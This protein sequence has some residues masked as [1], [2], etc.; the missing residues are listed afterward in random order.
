MKTTLQSVFTI[1]LLSL[2]LSVSAQ[3]RYLDDVFSAVTVTSD[4]TYATNISILPMLQGLPPGPANLKCDIYEPTG[5]VLTDRPVIILVHTGSFLPP[6]LNGQPTGS[7]SDLSIVEQCTRWAKKGYVAVAM[8]NRLGWNPTSTDQN[9][10][11]S[12]LIQAAYRGIQDAR[13]MVRYMRMTE[14]TGNS[15]GIDESKIVIGGQ[16]TGAYIS[17]GVATLDTASEMYL[18]KFMN[19]STTPPSP[20]V[21]A[22][23]FGNVYGTDSTYL[24][25]FASPTGQTELWNIPNNPTYSSDVNMA[26]NLGGALADISWLDAGEIPIVSFHCEKDPYGP[27]DTGDVIVPT[28]GNIVVEVMG[29][30]VVQH[31]ANQYLNNDPFALAGISDVYT[32]A[33]NVNN[34]GLE[35]LNVFITPP[36]SATSNAFGE[37]WEEEGA[38]W[39]WWDNVTYGIQ[40]EAVNGIPGQTSAAFFEAN[41]ILGSPNMS[42]ANGNLYIDTIQGY[43]NPRLFAVLGFISGCTDATSCNYNASA[44]IDD[45]TCILPDGCTDPLAC[46]YDNLATCDDGSCLTDYGCMN[47]AATNYDPLATCPDSCIFP[48]VTYGCTDST[49][50][51]YNPTASIDDTSCCFIAGCTDALAFNYDITACYDD[52]SCIPVALGCTYSV[53]CNYDASANSDDGSC[54]FPDGCTD[55]EAD[56]YDPTA[57]CDDGSCLYPTAINEEISGLLM[58]PNPANN[59][60]TIISHSVEIENINIYNLNGQL[61]LN[62]VLNNHNTVNVSSLESGIYI[63]DILSENTSVKRKLIIE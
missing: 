23:F 21:Y 31:Y 50:Y 44:N 49:A 28:T 34:G 3:T 45:G 57:L 56:N 16:G 8:D 2:G 25:D 36:P 40:A 1:A 55:D 14:A 27:I 58:Y 51:N 63:V 11:T 4:V 10:R 19:L 59:V 26:F 35:G 6:V 33:A 7:K 30:R 41:A 5:D 15:Y 61:V 18:P 42:A 47:P 54:I 43:L 20:Y 9:V 38:P 24:P 37:P 48:V 60:L 32:T 53:A 39:D 29:S 52:G 12:T 22:P 17:L 46:N 13:A 62:K